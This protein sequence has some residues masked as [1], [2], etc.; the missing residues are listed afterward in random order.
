M[1][2]VKQKGNRMGAVPNS[3]P[4]KSEN[5]KEIS[6]YLPYVYVCYC[7]VLMYVLYFWLRLFTITM[8]FL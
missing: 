2:Y 3:F 6:E 1:K 4:S 7:E 5:Q 8:Y